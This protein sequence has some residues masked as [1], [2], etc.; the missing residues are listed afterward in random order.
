M[1]K[2]FLISLLSLSLLVT[3][4]CGSAN[5]STG[6]EAGEKKSVTLKLGHPSP[7]QH[8]YGR[9]ATAFA[10]DVE[11]A[12]EGRLKIEVY[13]SAQLGGQRAL[14]EQVQVGTLDMSLTSSGPVTNFV[15]ELSVLDLPFLFDDIEHVHRSLDGELGK[16]FAEKMEAAGFKSLGFMDFGFKNFVTTGKPVHKADDLKGMKIRA[17]ESPIIVETYSRLGA[18]PTTMDAA[19][20]FTGLQQG[21]INAGQDTFGVAESFKLYEVQDYI[22]KVPMSYGGAVLMINN[23][24]FNSLDPELQKI[25]LEAGKKNTKLQRQVNQELEESSEKFVKENGMEVIA[26][27]NVDIE[28]FKNAIKPVYDKYGDK[29]KD[30]ITI[31]ESNK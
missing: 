11:E 23:K 31:V 25:L 17:Q 1:R 27:E 24:I 20:V 29:Y 18:S 10:K 7:P 28:S 12:S 14:I 8:S 13:D 9:A 4:G 26:Y 30:L 5:E 21:V 15:D 2:R 19:E 3:A 22:T 16:V 6:A